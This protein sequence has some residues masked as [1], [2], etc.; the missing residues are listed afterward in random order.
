VEVF[1]ATLALLEAGVM[2]RET[3]VLLLGLT[4]NCTEAVQAE[5]ER[6]VLDRVATASTSD[7]RRVVEAVIPEVEAD[8]DLELT[9]ERL[10]RSRRGRRV[11]VSPGPDGMQQVT[12]VLDPVQTRRW[13]LDFEEL[14]RAQKL[15]DHQT[16]TVR[17]QDQRRA[18]LFAGLP[19]HLL[20][21]LQ[22]IRQGNVAEL[23]ALAARDPDL[24]DRLEALAGQAPAPEAPAPRPP[25]V[26]ELAVALLRLPVRNPMVLNVHIPMTTVLDRDHRS[27][28]VEGLGPIPAEHARLLVPYAGL[29][30]VFVDPASG[31]PTGLDPHLHPALLGP[32]QPPD[33]H[34]AQQVRDRLLALLGPTTTVHHTEPRHDPSRALSEFV[35]LRDQRCTGLGCSRPA[36]RCE[37]DHETRYPDGPTAAWNLSAKSPRCHRAKHHGWQVDR[38][39]TGQSRWTSPLG[40]SYTRPGVWQAPPAV[41]HDLTLGPPRLPACDDHDPYPRDRPLWHQPPTPPPAPPPE[42]QHGWHDDPQF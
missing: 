26:E 32:D 10:E 24:A 1:G 9:R 15:T 16:G 12:G 19:G 23:L 13:V 35:Q 38:L 18:D 37:L 34:T 4:V 17:T 3:A 28:W 31:V 22:A 8:L 41:P 20:A 11:W 6:R 36:R 7:V 29:R 14:V 21:L 27:G 40:H 25:T 2:F 30:R 5:V 39:D 42:P 33:E